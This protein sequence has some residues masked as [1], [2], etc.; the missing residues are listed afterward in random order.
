MGSPVTT[1]LQV[2]KG[3]VTYFSSFGTSSYL[4]KGWS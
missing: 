1:Y 3:Y 4:R 2:V